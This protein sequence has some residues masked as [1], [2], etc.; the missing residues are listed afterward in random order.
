[1]RRFKKRRR[2]TV[3]WMPDQSAF[4]Q[5]VFK[6]LSN[7][8][9]EG[10]T[11]FTDI[12]LV[13]EGSPTALAPGGSGPLGLSRIQPESLIV[14][15]ITGKVCW[16]IVNNDNGE[17][18]VDAGGT[19]L[20]QIRTAIIIAGAATDSSGNPDLE[21]QL[22]TGNPIIN[23][24]PGAN[25]PTNNQG[26]FVPDGV[27]FLWRR[28]WFLAI[29]WSEAGASINN[30]E[31]CPPGPYLDIKP[32]RLLRPNELLRFAMQVTSVGGTGADGTS[33]VY[34]APDLRWAAHNT[35]RRR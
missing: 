31:T 4:S 15:H 2:S 17:S 32:K 20:Y 34:I 12:P 28:N 19:W 8:N 25:I 33:G 24:S 7:P 26:S 14:D 16:S 6:G 29:D 5:F 30:E 35:T 10:S 11:T 27:R 3:R 21:G 9:T 1:M 18:A 22:G 23:L 13:P